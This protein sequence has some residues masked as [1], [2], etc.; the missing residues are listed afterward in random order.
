MIKRVL[1]TAAIAAA[2]LVPAAPSH[3][4]TCAAADPTVDAVVCQTVYPVA[5]GLTCKVKL[6]CY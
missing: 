4:T 3:A 5:A 6:F 2:M 1:A